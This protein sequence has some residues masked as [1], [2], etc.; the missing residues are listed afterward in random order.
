M[1][2]AAS[3]VN[4]KCTAFTYSNMIDIRYTAPIQRPADIPPSHA[5]QSFALEQPSLEIVDDDE[6]ASG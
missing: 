4:T 2:A 3:N 5:K 1:G 6:A